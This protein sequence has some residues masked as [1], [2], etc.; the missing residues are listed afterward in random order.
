MKRHVLILFAAVI[1]TLTLAS[2]TSKYDAE[3]FIGKTSAEIVDE[4]GDFDCVIDEAD[5][6]IYSNCKCGYTIKEK[7]AGFLGSSDEVLFFI[8][9]DENSGATSC[10]EGVRP[11]G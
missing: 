10:A 4:N 2:C 1:F 8:C 3:D 11:G 7:K 5:D 6:G 9:F